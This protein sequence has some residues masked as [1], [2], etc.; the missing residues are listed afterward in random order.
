MER[1]IMLESKIESLVV[2]EK[3]IDEITEKHRIPEELHGNLSIAVLEG[4]NNAISHGNKFDPSKIVELKLKIKKAKLVVIIRDQGKGF[5]FEN[6][7]D[8]TLPGN[9]E[10]ISGRGIYLMKHL[11]DQLNFH[12]DGR[13]SELVF[14]LTYK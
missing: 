4:V 9:I 3:L 6:I 1:I 13:A 14:N 7:P 2:V 11:S 5:D 10:N 12:E 8:P